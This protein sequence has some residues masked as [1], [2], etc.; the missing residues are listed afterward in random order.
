MNDDDRRVYM[1]EAQRRFRERTKELKAWREAT[2]DDGDSPPR[3]CTNDAEFSGFG[4]QNS[5]L[6]GL[7]DHSDWMRGTTKISKWSVA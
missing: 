4:E 1:A 6:R 2:E 7:L 3:P 5:S